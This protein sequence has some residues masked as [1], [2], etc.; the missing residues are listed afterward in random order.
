MSM[1]SAWAA[2]ALSNFGDLIL[3]YLRGAGSHVMMK[4]L[5]S[6]FGSDT[7]ATLPMTFW[8]HCGAVRGDQAIPPPI[9]RYTTSPDA[10][11]RQ[12]QA[13]FTRRYLSTTSG[14]QRE[15]VCEVV[16][17]SQAPSGSTKAE[18]GAKSYDA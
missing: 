9:K 18:L 10:I 4:E 17:A 8:I 1:G 12:P 15:E 16:Q 2:L 5:P 13:A 14:Y 11:F 3:L 6:H 7:V